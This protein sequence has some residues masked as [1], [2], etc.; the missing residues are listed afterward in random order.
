MDIFLLSR[1]TWIQK[2]I[3]KEGMVQGG[4]MTMMI[5]AMVQVIDLQEVEVEVVVVAEERDSSSSDEEVDLGAKLRAG[6]KGGGNHSANI[7]IL[8]FL[9]VWN[10][11][12]KKILSQ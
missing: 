6:P 4:M 11:S 5:Q 3:I 8:Y 9:D 1:L 7:F 12:Y 10:V 2:F